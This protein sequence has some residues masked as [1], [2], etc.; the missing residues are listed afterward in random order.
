VAQV[1]TNT[2]DNFW[3]PFTANRDF[4]NEPRLFAKGEGV[5]YYS[6]KGDRIIDGTAGL[7]CSAL[8]HG[9][10]EI[11]D[12]VYRQ[13]QEM[14]YAP[15]FNSGHPISFEAAARVARI[16][17]EGMKHVF[18]ANSG[19]EAV[20]TALKIAYAYHK[21]KG[22]AERFRFVSRERAYHGV[23]FGG[24]SLAGLVKNRDIFGAGIPGVVHMRHT[25]DPNNLF[26]KG[27]PEKGAELADDLQRFCDLYGAHTIAACIVEPIAGST[28][29]LVP[30]KGYLQRLREI[31]DRTGILLIFDEVICGFG[32]TGKA[33][34]ADSFGVIPDMMTLAKA[35][36]N[37]VQPMGA[38]VVKDE[39]HDTIVNG[40]PE[41]T[42]EFFHG[43]TYSAHPGAC[44]A[45]I[46][47][48]D[49]YVR[50]KTF[51]KA[52]AMSPY[53]LDALFSL[54][55][56]PVLKDIRGYGMLGAFEVKPAGGPGVRGYEIMK[57]LFH[58]G[59]H[60]KFTGDSGCVSPPLIIEKAQIDDMISIL[61]DVLGKYKA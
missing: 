61:R 60:I 50:E 41:G 59:L 36:T 11:I 2:L 39:I 29:I 30:P 8:G 37:A 13:L 35:L 19:S 43:Y 20:D 55:D 58:A 34:G 10:K 18:F 31:C 9:R 57:K 33:F 28:G 7:F 21:A 47:T 14:D 52:A 56:L 22:Q 38:V 12:A 25:W 46:A 51:E 32:R 15:S 5:Y 54:K 24:V 17:P 44:A 27:Q 40:A 3:M 42:I 45:C 16:T 53:F 23:N 49:L 6:H 26:V 4:K 1:S 48:Q